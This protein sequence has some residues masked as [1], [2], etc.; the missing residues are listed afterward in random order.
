M[1]VKLSNEK[2]MLF[3]NVMASDAQI[4]TESYCNGERGYQW[5]DDN[6]FTE[7]RGEGTPESRLIEFFTADPGANFGDLSGVMIYLG[8]MGSGKSTTKEY[9]KNKLIKKYVT[10]KRFC[11]QRDKVDTD[12]SCRMNPYILDIHWEELDNSEDD[13]RSEEELYEE[14]WCDLADKISNSYEHR[15]FPDSLEVTSFWN[16]VGKC[17]NILRKSRYIDNHI[18]AHSEMIKNCHEGNEYYGMSKD[19]ILGELLSVR[20]EFINSMPSKD[21]V[22]YEVLKIKYFFLHSDDVPK[23]R[24]MFV[25]N[26]DQLEPAIQ[27]KAVSFFIFVASFLRLRTMIGIRPVTWKRNEEGLG[28]IN[29]E[30]HYSPYCGSVIERRFN[31]FLRDY[32]GQYTDEELQALN[33]FI[34]YCLGRSHHRDFSGIM[35]AA[36]GTSIRNALRAF[37]NMLL[38]LS[39]NELPVTDHEYGTRP[40]SEYVRAFFFADRDSLITT[41]FENLYEVGGECSSVTM[42]VKPRI[43][44]YLMTL[45]SHSAKISQLRDH[46]HL[47][48]IAGDEMIIMA[49]NEMLKRA[50]PLVWAESGMKI[51][52]L[53]SLARLLLTPMGHN[54]YHDL[55]GNY[56]YDECM[57]AK[58][59]IEKVD[60]SE[61]HQHHKALTKCDILQ[62]IEYI[63]ARAADDYRSLFKGDFISMCHM[64]AAHHIRGLYKR[65][66]QTSQYDYGREQWIMKQYGLLLSPEG[67][68]YADIISGLE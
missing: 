56:L 64:H 25:D 68:D 5:D 40:I 18:R 33:C 6:K 48:G 39:W 22:W 60:P 16:Y 65:V 27:K 24:I 66:G 52:S 51:E 26:I 21:K 61:V 23:C 38:S 7:Y 29:T 59:Q 9:V 15:W 31:E 20:L 12:S 28:K 10:C 3:A 50:R 8:G 67:A 55:F 44:H 42:L 13:T 43:L 37:W 58:S 34:T 35:K 57:I 1:A 54:Y 11:K 4:H 63:D 14:F 36:C 2:K 53:N 45:P 41:V 49:I 30:I 47:F 32:S 17:K 19:E 62:S 46:L